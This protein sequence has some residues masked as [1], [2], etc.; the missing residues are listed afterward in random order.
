MTSDSAFPSEASDATKRVE[1]S[2]RR[3]FSQS[4]EEFLKQ[5]DRRNQSYRVGWPRLPPLPICTKMKSMAKILDKNSQRPAVFWKFWDEIQAIANSF[6]S[7][8]HYPFFAQRTPVIED[9]SETYLTLLLVV[10]YPEKIRDEDFLLFWRPLQKMEFKEKVSIEFALEGVIDG[11][12]LFPISPKETFFMNNYERIYNKVLAEIQKQ[13]EKWTTIEIAHFGV[14]GCVHHCPPTIVITTTT[15]R[16]NIWYDTIIPNVRRSLWR[17]PKMLRIEIIC[18]TGLLIAPDFDRHTTEIG[19]FTKEVIIGSSISEAGADK[20]SATVG[21]MIKLENGMTYGLSNDHVFGIG[22]HD[23]LTGGSALRPESLKPLN[24]A[25][26]CPSNTDKLAFEKSI[27]AGLDPDDDEA[28]AALPTQIEN[29]RS[30]LR[31][32][33]EFNN[34]LGH[35]Y[36]TSGNRTIEYEVSTSGPAKNKDENEAKIAKSGKSR[37]DYIVDWSLIEISPNRTMTNKVPSPTTLWGFVQERT[38]WPWTWGFS[39]DRWTS[40]S[41]PIADMSK[42]PIGVIKLGRITGSYEGYINPIPVIINPKFGKRGLESLTIK[43]D[44]DEFLTEDNCAHA[45]AVYGDHDTL[46][47][48]AMPRD[49]GSLALREDTGEWLGLFFGRT[50]MGSA[51][52][53]PI[54][55]VIRDIEKVTGQR[56]VEPSFSATPRIRS[57]QNNA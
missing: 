37:R 6:G 14:I 51:L 10:E 31:Q 23:F 24:L 35:L 41:S 45:L 9:P 27:E 52:M 1:D 11:F 40:L 54:E 12:Y 55:A 13:R 57:S 42:K 44:R 7:F 39:C 29:N 48:V 53:T 25:V 3:W 21:G 32:A 19:D 43:D 15:A 50:S 49:C 46:H 2:V 26:N 56:V 8:T 38:R 5:V 28:P 33:R 34:L 4:D 36:A 16:K 22:A 18:D 30:E 17:I 47:N 20:P